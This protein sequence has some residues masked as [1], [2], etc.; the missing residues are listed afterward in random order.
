M[1]FVPV[2][3]RLSVSLLVEAAVPLCCRER[4][5]DLGLGDAAGDDAVRPVPQQRSI[6]T[7]MF[8]DDELHQRAGVE[9]GDGHR[10][11]SR[12]ATTRS[13]TG[14]SAL[15]RRRSRAVGRA[16]RGGPLIWPV[17]RVAPPV[18][19][20]SHPRRRRGRVPTHVPRASRRS[21]A[22]SQHGAT[23]SSRNDR[24]R[25]SAPPSSRSA[26]ARSSARRPSVSSP[27]PSTCPRPF[28]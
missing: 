18:A 27:K 28:S 16:A 3:L 23:R 4:G 17:Q 15:T 24:L 11:A 1:S 26:S 10:R 8:V 12:S 25:A 22:Y 7:A 2:G 19:P 14:P 21:R 9:V 13:A 20:R 5:S 6:L